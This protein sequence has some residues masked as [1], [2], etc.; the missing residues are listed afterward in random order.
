MPTT[1]AKGLRRASASGVALPAVPAFQ[2][3]T[4]NRVHFRRGQ[5]SMVAAVPNAGKSALAQYFA[6]NVGVPT[7]YFSA[8]QDDWT[9]STRLAATITGN[10]SWQVADEMARDPTYYAERLAESQ[11]SYCFDASPSV[12]DI[13]HELD[14]YVEMYDEWPHLIVVDNLLN[15]QDSGE[16]QVDQWITSEL[17]YL[18]RKTRAHVMVLVHASEAS[19]KDPLW[20]PTRKD[21]LNKLSK[22]PELVLTLAND[23]NGQLLVAVVKSRETKADPTAQH[24]Y[25]LGVDFERMQIMP[26]PAQRWGYH[27]GDWRE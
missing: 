22:F 24:P 3:L 5:L 11:V 9:T 19:T 21:I 12:E 25:V 10:P 26:Q 18:A 27:G 8:D 14:A 23:G 17:H 7:L 1:A 4:G 15:I 13:G 2:R 20:P 6:H 16:L